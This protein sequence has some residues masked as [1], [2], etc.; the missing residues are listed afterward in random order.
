[1]AVPL[2]RL[3][4]AR[5]GD[6]GGNANVGFWARDERGY[7]W[8][9][10]HLTVERFKELLTEA[11]LLEVSR[12]LLPNVLAVNFVVSGLIAPGVA[13]TARPDAQ[14]KGLGEYLRSRIVEVPADL[15]PG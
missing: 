3:Y 14:A 9:R 11:K 7:S 12:F 1:V 10:D 13:A 15:L 6:K 5:S 8:L 4:G 2:G